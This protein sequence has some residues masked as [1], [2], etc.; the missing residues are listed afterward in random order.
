M[1]DAPTMN[2]T[3]TLDPEAWYSEHNLNLSLG[4]PQAAM[5]QARQTGQLRSALIGGRVLF[6]GAWVSAWLENAAP[7]AAPSPAS[8]SSRVPASAPTRPSVPSR[9]AATAPASQE[10]LPMTTASIDRPALQRGSDLFTA[11]VEAREAQGVPRAQAMRET[12]ARHPDEHQAFLELAQ[13]EARE[14][15]ARQRARNRRG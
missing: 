15:A 8:P 14:E 6:R 13:I 4:I 11:R 5:D 7:T 10:P 12:V 3:R 1:S 9:P 2:A